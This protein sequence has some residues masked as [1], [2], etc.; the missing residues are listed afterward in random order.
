MHTRR[1]VEINPRDSKLHSV[2]ITLLVLIL[3]YYIKNHL[4]MKVCQWHSV[5]YMH[6]MVVYLTHSAQNSKYDRTRYIEQC[7]CCTNST[8]EKI[9]YSLHSAHVGNI[10]EL[11][12]A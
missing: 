4:E 5:L 3:Q 7:C 10:C 6:H 8:T 1:A 12:C 11:Q 2:F 9:T